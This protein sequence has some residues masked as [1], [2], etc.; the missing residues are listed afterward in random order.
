[1]ATGR[2]QGDN[3]PYAT[4][5]RQEP[6]ESDHGPKGFSDTYKENL[7]FQWYQSGGPSITTLYKKIEPNEAGKVPTLESVKMWCF[8]LKWHDRAKMLNEEI[9]RQ[10]QQ[11]MIEDRI[12]ML[13]RQADLGR[14]LQEK[15]QQFFLTH[16]IDSPGVALKAI[17]QG[18][19]LERFSRGIPDAL[20][21]VS[22]LDDNK[23]TGLVSKLL[24]GIN[25]SEEDTISKAIDYDV[26]GVIVEPSS[27]EV[28]EV[29]DE[30]QKTDE[31]LLNTLSSFLGEK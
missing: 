24:A 26:D 13:H 17:I 7:F 29:R 27:V 22:Q 9:S 30:E 3:S 8:K 28:E 23:L 1:M 5:S 15:G 10:I 11:R 25:P 20:L 21:R 12:E 2:T 14:T 19:E 16:E 4:L 18:A 31:E 6:G